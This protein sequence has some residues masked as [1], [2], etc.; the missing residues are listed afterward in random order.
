MIVHTRQA[1]YE[2]F[3]LFLGRRFCDILILIL[4]APKRAPGW[5]AQ[6]RPSSLRLAI[7]SLAGLS[8]LDAGTL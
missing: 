1:N 3:L 6:L 4:R 8:E 5:E 7:H 2:S